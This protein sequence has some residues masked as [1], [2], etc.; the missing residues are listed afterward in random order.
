MAPSMARERVADLL[1]YRPAI[2]PARLPEDKP[3]VNVA[4]HPDIAPYFFGDTGTLWLTE[5]PLRDSAV[6]A[7]VGANVGH[8]TFFMAGR[9]GRGGRVLSFEPNPVSADLI[10]RTIGANGLAGV[11]QV[12]RRGLRER[13]GETRTGNSGLS[14]LVLHGDHLSVSRSIGDSLFISSPVRAE[15]ISTFPGLAT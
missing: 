2:R 14:S 8:Y 7:D 12:D 13:S 9:G 11:G 15:F 5:D 3:W 1:A 6:C 10:E 4:E